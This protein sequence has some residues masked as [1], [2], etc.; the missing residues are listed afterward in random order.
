MAREAI[1]PMGQVVPQQWL[2][3]TT[4]PGVAQN[5]RRRL[6]MAICSVT[7]WGGALCCDATLVSSLWREGLP[8]CRG[9]DEDG[10]ALAAA[11]RRKQTLR[12]IYSH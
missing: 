7:T 9:A 11:E 5:G 12:S 2:T 4:A 3:H 8:Q 10:A 1:G 6:D